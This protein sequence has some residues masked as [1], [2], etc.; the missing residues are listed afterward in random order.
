MILN[1][2]VERQYKLISMYAENKD[3]YLLVEIDQDGE[4]NLLE[5]NFSKQVASLIDLHLHHQ[6]SFPMFISAVT[7]ELF[8]DQTILN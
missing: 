7:Q 2:S 6:K 4:V 8:S 5:S 1:G 3:D